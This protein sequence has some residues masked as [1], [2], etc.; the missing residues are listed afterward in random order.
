LKEGENFGKNNSLSGKNVMVDYTDPNPFK[1]FHI[2]H[3]MSN[4]IGESICRIFESGGAKVIRVCYQGDVGLH[5]A[6]ALW[7]IMHDSAGLPD[8]DAPLSGKIS[9]IGAAYALGSQKYEDD[10]KIAIEIKEINRKVFEKSDAEINALYEKGRRWSLSHFDEIYK[11][12]GTAFNHIIPES[13]VIGDGQKIVEEFLSKGVFEKSDGAV[14]FHG[15]KYGLHTRVFISSLGLPTYE[16]K[17][18]GLAQK[19][20]GLEKKLSASIIVTANEQNDYFKVV[21]K[22][23]SFIFPDY[24]KISKHIGHGMLRLPTGKMSSRTGNVITGESLISAVEAMVHKKLEERELET[25]EKNKIAEIVAIGAIKY[26]ILR[27]AIGSDIIY[28]FEKSISFEGDSGPYLQYSYVRAESVLRKAELGHLVSKSHLDTKCPIGEESETSLLERL[29]CRFPEI[30]E[31]AGA[32]FSPH[33]IATYLI[34]LAGA[35]NNYYAH[36]QI[37]NPEDPN[38]PYKVSLT[39]AFATVMKSG[40]WLLGIQS[41]EKM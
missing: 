29:L 38:S 23:L 35:F 40:L 6:K 19:K 28:D 39:K 12:L 10:P 27:Q 5:V 16:T 26:S 32:E 13:S 15:E 37:V 17:D 3:L 8:D 20:I 33:Y 22:A 34:E 41:P 36:N 2:G 1:E 7:G 11:K 14:V 21:F 31:R 9:Y 25:V 4:A 24:A 30:V 18:M